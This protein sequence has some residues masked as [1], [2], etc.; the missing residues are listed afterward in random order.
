V[1]REVEMIK[2]LRDRKELEGESGLK[3]QTSPL[4]ELRAGVMPAAPAITAAKA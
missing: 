1:R 4:S 3:L 2:K